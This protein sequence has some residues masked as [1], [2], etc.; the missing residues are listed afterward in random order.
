MC[1]QL[2]AQ[3]DNR[4]IEDEGWAAAKAGKPSSANPYKDEKYYY[5]EKGYTDYL[6]ALATYS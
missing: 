6:I 5:W 2:E 1:K 3:V 4:V